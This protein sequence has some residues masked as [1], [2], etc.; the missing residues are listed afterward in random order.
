LRFATV[1]VVMNKIPE[2]L[3]PI[4]QEYLWHSEYRRL[5]SVFESSEFRE[6]KNKTAYYNLKEEYSEEF[7]ENDLFRNQIL[8]RIVDKSKQISLHF[9]RQLGNPLVF[10]LAR[11]VHTLILDDSVDY[12]YCFNDITEFSGIHTLDM[13]EGNCKTESLE[14]LTDISKIRLHGFNGIVDVSPLASVRSVSLAFCCVLESVSCLGNVHTLCIDNCHCVSDISGLGRNNYKISLLELLLITDVNHLARVHNLVIKDCPI[15]GVQ[16]LGAVHTLSLIECSQLAALDGLGV[17][18]RH[19]RVQ[20]CHD[21][22][23]FS[24]LKSCSKVLIDNCKGFTE[25]SHLSGVNTLTL[26]FIDLASL[27][28]VEKV[29]FLAFEW[30]K[31][32]T[33]FGTVQMANQRIELAFCK[34]LTDVTLLS[35]V[36][37]VH[38]VQCPNI[39]DLRCLKDCQRVVWFCPRRGPLPLGLSELANITREYSS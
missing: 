10:Q 30:C 31:N 1:S 21:I 20:G 33:S 3:F 7:L 25:G 35:L 15:T 29:R 37:E 11:G 12:S 2:L 23:D 22:T 24:P 4:I 8:S 39:A 9:Y 6:L 13:C 32:L 34:K 36:A 5:L 28:G 18:N 19:V 14:G 38:F 16:S 26:R 27:T 17:Q